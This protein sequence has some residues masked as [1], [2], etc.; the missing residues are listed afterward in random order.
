MLVSTQQSRRRRSSDGDP[1]HVSRIHEALAASGYAERFPPR[2]GQQNAP[3]LLLL[4]PHGRFV[5]PFG[6]YP[7]LFTGTSVPRATATTKTTT[8]TTLSLSLCLSFSSSA[9]TSLFLSLEPNQTTRCQRAV[10]VRTG[11]ER[12]RVRDQVSSVKKKKSHCTGASDRGVG[13]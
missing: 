10:H 12:E 7:H 11:R 4:S 9:K 1:F 6:S 5:F 3:F 8:N 2:E 13:R